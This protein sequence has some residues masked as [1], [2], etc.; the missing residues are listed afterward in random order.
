MTWIDAESACQKIG[1]AHLV[2]VH[3]M[4]ESNIVNVVIGSTLY[5]PKSAWIGLYK[6]VN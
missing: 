6:D 4:V 1:N 5:K 2:S 3:N